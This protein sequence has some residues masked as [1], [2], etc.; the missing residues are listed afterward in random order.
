MFMYW[1]AVLRSRTSQR[2]ASRLTTSPI[3]FTFT[4]HESRVV[5]CDNVSCELC[6]QQLYVYV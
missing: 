6:E 3:T 4:R 1:V 5:T 2:V